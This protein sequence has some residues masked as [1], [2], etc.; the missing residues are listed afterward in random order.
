MSSTIGIN[1]SG[2]EYSWETFPA[3]TDLDYLK[4]EGI[5]LIRLPISWERMQ[6]TLDG[7][8][9]ETYFAGL[10][11]FLDQAAQKGIQV[12]VDL[13]NYG[14]YN[15]GFAADAAA[16]YGIQGPDMWNGGVIGS[17]QVP[18]SAFADLWSKLA[19]ALAGNPAVAYFDIMNE[20]HDMGGRDVW[21]A[22]AQAAVDAIRAVDTTTK[23][24]V[25][26]T[27]WASAEYWQN[28]NANLH[29]VDPA[30][31]LLYEAHLYLDDGGTNY[32][33]STY[34]QIT[35]G[36]ANIGVEKLASFEAW[37][38]AN[39]AQGFI[40]EFGAPNNDPAWSPAINNLLNAM[41]AYGISGTA[42]TYVRDYSGNQPWWPN[43][44]VLNIYNSSSP[45]WELEALFA[46]TS[47]QI[48]S[49]ARGAVDSAGVLTFQ[50]TA[51]PGSTVE[52][53]DG[54]SEVGTAKV[55]GNGIWSFST[56][57][58]PTSDHSFTAIAISKFGTA[59]EPSAVVTMTGLVNGPTVASFSPDSA[60]AGD[61]ITNVNHITLTGAAAAGTTV[62]VFD[63]ATQ[64]GTA[65]ANVS[66]TWSFA[67]ATLA[68]G[69]H[70]FTSKAVDAAG[71]ISAAS[72]ALTV[73]IDTVAP[74]APTVAS[75]S[76]DS[77]VAGD[78]ITNVNHITLTGTAAAGTTVR[79]FDGAAQIG[80]ATANASGAWSL[81]TG[82]LADGVHEITT[83]AADDA[84]NVSAASAELDVTVNTAWSGNPSAVSVVHIDNL[85]KATST[86]LVTIN[87]NT[88]QT[89]HLDTSGHM[90]GAE[91]SG[92]DG[93]ST[94][95]M[96]FDASW[97]QTKADVITVNGNETQTVHLDAHWQIT[98][99]DIRS[100]DGNSATTIQFNS[101]WQQTGAEVSTIN[102]ATRQTIYFDAKWTMIGA[103][104]ANVEGQSTTLT[105]FDANWRMTGAAI[106]TPQ[107]VTSFDANWHQAQ[108][109]SAV[110]QAALNVMN[111]TADN[112]VF[113][114]RGNFGINVITSFQAGGAG[115]DVIQLDHTTFGDFNAVM[116]SAV[117]S[118]D[119]VVITAH[120]G[121]IILEGMQLAGLHPYDFHLV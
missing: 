12:I 29:I 119:A 97:H 74:S 80:T 41:Q 60:V 3:A 117:Q 108:T 92:A 46:H 2:A 40:G 48:T 81:A 24:L 118:G 64:I 28:D 11:T 75:F 89:V 20:P 13:H 44:D 100:V 33:N 1:V 61:G 51:A 90:L 102:G 10:K 43:G 8:L 58:H 22:A 106:S 68:D 98:G 45:Q 91:V 107:A 105:Y 4:S 69:S 121:S 18:I 25:E 17:A 120:E 66:G 84:G 35:G 86:D 6:P 65:T 78:G 15:V 30:G 32:Y 71:N 19:S 62:Q 67:T 87:G 96:Y 88:T 59:S 103:E 50:G 57:G 55:D 21:P 23:I 79:V 7:P 37:L 14:R 95:T 16:N 56:S 52:I 115:H 85:G 110:G 36:N 5:S 94:T 82:T 42:W 53:F 99:A 112:D 31:K 72:A 113:V 39:N 34:Q 111:G 38:K 77:A 9:N 49:V 70:A 93:A 101:A 104:V 63:G 73:T 27:Q 54:T 76:P 83:K 114:F 109:N 116:A 26:G 47:P